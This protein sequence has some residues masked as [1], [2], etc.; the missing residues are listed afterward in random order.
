VEIILAIRTPTHARDY[1]FLVVETPRVAAG[2]RDD[3][4][5]FENGI[6]KLK[7]R[8]SAYVFIK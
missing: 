7:I 1:Y 6:K 4:L 5:V 8:S 3:F 2:I